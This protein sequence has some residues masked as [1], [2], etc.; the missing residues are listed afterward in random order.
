MDIRD[1]EH[2][3][4]E[5][6]KVILARDG[7]KVTV[8]EEN[9]KVVLEKAADDRIKR[10]TTQLDNRVTVRS[11]GFLLKTIVQNLSD[12]QLKTYFHVSA[13]SVVEDKEKTR[14]AMELAFTKV[15]DII[16]N[17]FYLTTADGNGIENLIDSIIKSYEC[18]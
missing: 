4:D 13:D 18:S 3:I 6:T 15:V 14:E 5:N 8:L 1:F 10:L 11:Y 2:L 17:Y 7:A 12:A 9:T 16:F